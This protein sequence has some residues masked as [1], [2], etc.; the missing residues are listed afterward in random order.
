MTLTV[1]RD[2]PDTILRN[3]EGRNLTPVAM[4]AIGKSM[5]SGCAEA[6]TSHSVRLPALL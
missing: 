4:M 2:S 6:A 5:D 1:V 3:A